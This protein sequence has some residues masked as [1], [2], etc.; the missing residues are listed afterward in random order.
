MDKNIYEKIKIF[1]NAPRNELIMNDLI[2][3]HL[4]TEYLYDRI[5]K[6]NYMILAKN[7]LSVE[8]RNAIEEEAKK[9]CSE[10]ID[11]ESDT[12]ESYFFKGLYFRILKERNQAISH[13]VKAAEKGLSF[14]YYYLCMYSDSAL[15]KV[16]N[17]RHAYNLDKSV[18]AFVGDLAV[19]KNS[20][21]LYSDETEYIAELEKAVKLGY[22]LAYWNLAMQYREKN[23]DEDQ[24]KYLYYLGCSIAY[25]HDK[26][27]IQH[28]L[29]KFWEYKRRGLYKVA[30]ILAAIIGGIDFNLYLFLISAFYADNIHGNMGRLLN[31]DNALLKLNI[32]REYLNNNR[33]KNTDKYNEFYDEKLCYCSEEEKRLTTDEESKQRFIYNTRFAYAGP[34]QILKLENFIDYKWVEIYLNFHFTL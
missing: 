22:P 9:E 17:L 7:I 6:Y 25:T 2:N 1:V 24:K 15:E 28:Y 26:D 11:E 31:L 3:R 10:I 13:F 33:D 14:G 21:N 18:A 34:E 32:I 4:N 12:A 8:E 20:A 16:L 30:F 23:S 29:N 19:W 5:L 27:A